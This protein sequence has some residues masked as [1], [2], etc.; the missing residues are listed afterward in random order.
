M[1]GVLFE[2]NMNGP[3]L[4]FIW[5]GRGHAYSIRL[6][7]LTAVDLLRR[8]TIDDKGRLYNGRKDGD[9]IRRGRGVTADP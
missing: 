3:G 6:A 4:F 2:R 5:I 1:N 7:G 9:S 8:G